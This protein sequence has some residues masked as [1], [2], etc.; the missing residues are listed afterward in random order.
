MKKNSYLAHKN[1]KQMKKKTC[2]GPK[3]QLLVWA[4]VA[5]EMARLE[6]VAVLVV[7]EVG[8][9]VMVVGVNRVMVVV[10]KM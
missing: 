9:E 6:P 4:R 10:V 7:V 1:N 5:S 2:L 8:V 3:R